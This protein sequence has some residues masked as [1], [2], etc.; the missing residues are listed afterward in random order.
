MWSCNDHDVCNG[1][2]D[3]N[4]NYIY[5]ATGTF[6]FHVG[7]WGPAAPQQYEVNCSSNSC[8]S[9]GATGG[10]SRGEKSRGRPGK[11]GSGAVYLATSA[12]A[13]FAAIYSLI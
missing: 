1:T 7:C 10:Y 13:M 11:D 8:T 2:F 3:S 12:A 5:V 6:P 4:G 9:S